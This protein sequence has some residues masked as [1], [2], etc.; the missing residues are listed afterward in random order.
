L[1][2]EK[3]GSTGK[4]TGVDYTSDMLAHAQERVKREGWK[5]VELIQGDAVRIELGRKF[6]AA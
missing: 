6:D 1:I 4:L 5:N 3:I 2:L